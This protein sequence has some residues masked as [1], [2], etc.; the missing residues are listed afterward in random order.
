MP[1]TYVL[2]VHNEEATLA[3]CLARLRAHLATQ[4]P[5]S[6]VLLVENGSKD[7]SADLARRLAAQ[8][9]PVPVY[10]Y[11]LREAG[12]GHAYDRG[13]REALRLG[14]P[15]PA[16]W[17]V[18]SAADLPFGFSDLTQARPH[19]DDPR[20]PLLI[21][22][23]A[24]PESV[25]QVS[26]ERAVAT[27]AYR[28]V[29]RMVA[30]MRTGDSQGTLFLRLDVAARLVDVIR[31]RDFFYSTE[32]VFH[33]EREGRPII[34]LPVMV[35]PERR[36]STVRPARDGAKMLMGLLRLVS[37]WGRIDG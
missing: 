6:D 31:A 34:E 11:S 33:V 17:L 29:R 2:P 37:G 36:S 13:I 19:L 16:R 10:A 7:G 20:A 14:G 9:H 21:G 1:L 18:L 32:L 8:P 23:K 24:H 4:Q 5:G 25:V 15:S 35:A 26:T 27:R 28:I 30:G 22:S 12:I 3:D